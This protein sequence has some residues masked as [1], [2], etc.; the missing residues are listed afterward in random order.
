MPGSEWQFLTSCQALNVYRLCLLNLNI[1]LIM[2]RG[3]DGGEIDGHFPRFRDKQAGTNPRRVVR[4]YDAI[5][6]SSRG[7][8]DLG[9]Y[10]G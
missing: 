8:E 6:R 7:P 5:Q 1:G 10:G 4:D 9:R 3:R 2:V